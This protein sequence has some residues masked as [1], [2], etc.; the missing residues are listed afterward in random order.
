MQYA[1]IDYRQDNPQSYYIAAHSKIDTVNF[2]LSLFTARDNKVEIFWDDEF[3]SYGVGVE[4]NK[5]FSNC[6]GTLLV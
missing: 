4:I 6:L 3:Y 5:K 2:L 1:E